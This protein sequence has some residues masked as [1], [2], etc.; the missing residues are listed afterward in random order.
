MDLIQFYGIKFS[1][2]GVLVI[3]KMPQMWRQETAK[4]SRIHIGYDYAKNMTKDEPVVA[5]LKELLFVEAGGFASI[6][7]LIF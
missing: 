1:R 3:L 2:D 5:N 6:K 4:I 7:S